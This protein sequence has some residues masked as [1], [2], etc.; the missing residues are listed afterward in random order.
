MFSLLEVAQVQRIAELARKAGDAH[1]QLI[2]GL[3]DIDLGDQPLERGSRN[4]T[5][6]DSLSV[7]EKTTKLGEITQLRAAI[8][9]LPPDARHELKA[10]MLIGRGDFAVGQWDQAMDEAARTAPSGD[11]DYLA[12]RLNLHQY[13]TKA[14][15]AMKCL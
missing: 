7:L 5:D 10:V 11:A 13:L 1:R 4:P 12:E 6:L 8:D 15:Y 2:G 3:H 9:A 14:L